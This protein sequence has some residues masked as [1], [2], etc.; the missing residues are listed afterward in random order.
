[1]VYCADTTSFT[2]EMIIATK[3]PQKITSAFRFSNWDRNH[4]VTE[5]TECRLRKI[6]LC[7]RQVPLPVAY[8]N[9]RLDCGYQMDIVVEDK[10]I[11]E[12][13]SIDC[14]LP[15]HEAQ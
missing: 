3:G 9:V 14:V 1:M 5:D 7:S 13:K 10:V 6:S 15:V 4:G 12:L 8:K 11:L 2:T